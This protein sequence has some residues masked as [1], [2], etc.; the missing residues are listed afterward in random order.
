MLEIRDLTFHYKNQPLFDNVSMRLESGE[1]AFLIGKSGTGKSTLLQMIYLNIFPQSGSLTIGNFETSFVK[2]KQIPLIRR[3]IGIV[4][5]D[6]KLLNDRNVYNNLA[7]VLEVTNHSGSE[8]KRI[9]NDALMEVGLSHKRLNYPNE[10][11]GG[12]MQRVA[13]ARAILNNP[14]I[15]LA[16]EPTGNLDPETSYE[17]LELL[18][19]IYKKG[20][21]VLFATHDYDLVRKYPSA[22]IFK[23][24]DRN[25]IKGY[26]KKSD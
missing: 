19:K 17:I 13:I 7:F 4:F 22:K 16:D 12:E 1:F 14:M 6:F 26:L 9:V 11:S 23:I 8:I 2:K 15:I 3:K 24:V 5:Q 20:T 21:S 25:I 10:L 18:I